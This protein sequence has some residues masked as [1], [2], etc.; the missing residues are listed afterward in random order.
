MFCIPHHVPVLTTL[1]TSE[2]HEVCL[3]DLS[4]LA[5]LEHYQW[6]SHHLHAKINKAG[7]NELY[8]RDICLSSNKDM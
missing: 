7:L 5:L 6:R 1:S 4:L 3:S 2:L 8:S